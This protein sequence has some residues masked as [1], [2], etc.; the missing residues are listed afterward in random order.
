M[1]SSIICWQSTC[2]LDAAG[3]NTA[4]QRRR[5]NRAGA[6]FG[7]GER[8]AF[9]SSGNGFF[10][11]ACGTVSTNLLLSRAPD[12]RERAMTVM[13]SSFCNLKSLFIIFRAPGIL[14]PP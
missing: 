1:I 4:Q 9:T 12:G 6:D 14:R 5:V 13:S 11:Q 7:A 3:A 2:R 10:P 8:S